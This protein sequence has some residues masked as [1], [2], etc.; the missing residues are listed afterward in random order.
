MI[1][2]VYLRSSFLLTLFHFL[3]FWNSI[4]TSAWHRSSVRLPWL[5]MKKQLS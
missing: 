3:S 5:I 1:F 2:C 4:A